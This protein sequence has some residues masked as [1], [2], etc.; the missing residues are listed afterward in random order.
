MIKVIF[1]GP[2]N[3]GDITSLATNLHELKAE[4]SKRSDLKDWLNISA[5]A[6]NGKIANSLDLELKNGDEVVLLPPVCGG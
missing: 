6:V 2:I 1:Q 3:E 4:L 5:I